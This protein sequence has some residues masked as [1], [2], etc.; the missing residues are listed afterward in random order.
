M[1]H[2]STE[3]ALPRFGEI[4]QSGAVAGNGS[5]SIHGA[6]DGIGGIMGAGSHRTPGGICAASPLQHFGSV[7][8]QGEALPVG[9][10]APCF[11]IGAIVRHRVYRI[12]R[13]AY[14]FWVYSD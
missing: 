5:I 12:E 11:I 2:G 13:S 3:D 10:E 1:Y 4:H 14:G 9:L 7:R 6:I 8:Q